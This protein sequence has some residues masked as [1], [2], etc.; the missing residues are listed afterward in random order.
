MD[1]LWEWTVKDIKDNA[2]WT[3]TPIIYMH[4]DMALWTLRLVFC[5]LRLDWTIEQYNLWKFLHSLRYPSVPINQV[6]NLLSC[7]RIFEIWC[8]APQVPTTR[9][10]SLMAKFLNLS[11]SHF[12]SSS[13]HNAKKLLFLD[14]TQSLL[15]N[16][17]SYEISYSSINIIGK[18]LD[19]FFFNENGLEKSTFS[20]SLSSNPSLKQAILIK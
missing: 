7:L 10:S 11:P 5:V 2:N 13:N 17:N 4:E 8:D 19:A 14:H 20:C 16:M 1:Q 6:T 15:N 18:H 3:E 9:A 12:L